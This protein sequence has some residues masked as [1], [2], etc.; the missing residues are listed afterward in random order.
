M[1]ATYASYI[2][3]KI[4]I[5]SACGLLAINIAALL[6]L[7]G[8]LSSNS[9]TPAELS[10]E[11][12]AASADAPLTVT[13]AS[14]RPPGAQDMDAAIASVGATPELGSWP[15]WCGAPPQTPWQ[16]FGVTSDGTHVVVAVASAGDGARLWQQ[17]QASLNGCTQFRIVASSPTSLTLSRTDVPVTWVVARHED[18]LVSVLQASATASTAALQAIANDVVGAASAQ[19]V[20]TTDDST[21]RNPWR[22]GYQPWHP[23]VP[24]D[25]PDPEGPAVPDVSALVDWTAPVAAPRPELAPVLK[26]DVTFNPYTTE[27]EAAPIGRVPVL[28]DP[29]QIVPPAVPRPPAPPPDAVPLPTTATAYFAKQDTVGPGCGWAFAGT[30][31]PTFDSTLPG[32][33]LEGQIDSAFATAA[34]DMSAWLLWTVDAGVNAQQDA[35][36]RAAL[37][38]WASYDN[39]YQK[40]MSAWQAALDRRTSSLNTWFAYVPDAPLTAP[41]GPPPTEAPTDIPTASPTASALPTPSV[42]GVR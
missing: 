37:A 27:N 36:T 33:E 26:P 38:A 28:V 20:A 41:S 14:V 6:L 34:S 7:V 21:T 31:P 25:T 5:I 24:I 32:K 2:M 15:S 12:A 23:A 29:A 1:A 30:V 40:A 22:P 4:V 35:Q 9:S 3:R 10:A 42:T 18:V 16:A 19:C 8:P 39:A 17:Q 13:P 11:S